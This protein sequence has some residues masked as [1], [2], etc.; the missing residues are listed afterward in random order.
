VG[1]GRSDKDGRRWWY[2][3]NASISDREGGGEGQWD[4]ALPEDEVEAASS[5]W[6]Y[7]KEA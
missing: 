6:L 3:F 2:G 7:G 4:E 5:T 1:V